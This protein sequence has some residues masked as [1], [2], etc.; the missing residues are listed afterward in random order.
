MK[1]T[2]TPTAL[3]AIVAIVGVGFDLGAGD[4]FDGEAGAVLAP[5][6]L[7]GDADGVAMGEAVADG[8]VVGGVGG[9]VGAGVVDELVQVAAEH[10]AGFVAEHLRG[11]G[12]DDGDVAVEVGAEDAV[13]DGLEDGVGLAG[14]GAEAAFDADLLADVDAE[15]EDV[16]QRGRGRR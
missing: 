9:A 7:V 8:G 4:V 16:G 15:A 14:E 11:G 6:D 5:E 13:A 10:L 12:V 1:A 2:T 3:P